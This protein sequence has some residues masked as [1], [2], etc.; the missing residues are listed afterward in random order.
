MAITHSHTG[1]MTMKNI[2]FYGLSSLIID[3]ITIY[4]I[5]ILVLHMLAAAAAAAATANGWRLNRFL[6]QT[7]IMNG[8]YVNYW[9]ACF[10]ILCEDRPI[11]CASASA[12]YRTT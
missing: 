10:R 1:I 2:I 5:S 4:D 9:F 7:T 6:M 3:W 12:C 8:K 11:P